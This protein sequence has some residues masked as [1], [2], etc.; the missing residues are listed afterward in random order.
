MLIQILY[1]NISNKSKILTQKGVVHVEQLQSSGKVRVKTSDGTVYEGDIL[2]GA[3]GIHSTVRREM[4]RMADQ[5]RPGLFPLKDCEKASTDC[6]CI[7][8]ISQPNKKFPKYSSQNVMGNG[9]SY[10]IATGPNHRIY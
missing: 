5:A 8:G 1:D 4:W 6:C 10:L 9:C 2:V 7:F 3:D